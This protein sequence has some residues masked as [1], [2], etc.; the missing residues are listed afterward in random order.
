MASWTF[1]TSGIRVQVIIQVEWFHRDT[2]YHFQGV[3][4]RK[5]RFTASTSC[6]PKQSDSV[7][8][9]WLSHDTLSTAT[10]RIYRIC[11]YTR[12]P[13][14]S[15][16]TMVLHPIITATLALLWMANIRNEA[17]QLHG[18]HDHLTWLCSRLSSSIS[19]F[20]CDASLRWLIGTYKFRK[21]FDM[22]RRHI[23]VSTR[24]I[25]SFP[26]VLSQSNHRG[27]H[28]QQ[29]PALPER[30]HKRDTSSFEQ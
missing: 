5:R 30:V 2:D 1:D 13:A 11:H 12:E 22:L 6:F 25:A 29:I 15:S 4:D 21:H 16:C 20:L 28:G 18:L 14:C 8:L 27:N 19:Y 7:S 9:S 17:D 24:R 10:D 3:G 26:C 23:S